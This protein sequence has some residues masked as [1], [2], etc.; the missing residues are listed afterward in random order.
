MIDIHSHILW[1]LDDGAQ[2]YSDSLAMLAIAAQCG[3]TDIVATPHSDL[4]FKFIPELV[5]H[6]IAQL[7]A[8]SSGV[9]RIHSGC[10]FHMSLENIQDALV[11]PRKYTIDGLGYLLVELAD[12]FIPRS[13]DEVFR[14]F[15]RRGIVPVITHPERNPLLQGNAARLQNWVGIGCAVQ[16]TAQSLGDRFGKRA[17]LSAWRLLKEGLVHVVASDAHDIADRPPRLDIAQK[18]L[19]REMGAR[20]AELLVAENPAAILIGAPIA[21]VAAEKR[22]YSFR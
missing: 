1:G 19:T 22:W 7:A 15:V 10:D 2:E 5:N 14:Q 18:A 9:P 17:M 4:R 13:M 20:A 21:P 16:I 12:A 11:F 8:A 6:R 3:T